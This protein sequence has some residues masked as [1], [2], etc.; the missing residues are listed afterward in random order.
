MQSFIQVI[1]YGEYFEVCLTDANVKE[2][3]ADINTGNRD[4]DY[5]ISP[6]LHIHVKKETIAVVQI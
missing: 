3:F 2:T 5:R 4:I 6:F 1:I